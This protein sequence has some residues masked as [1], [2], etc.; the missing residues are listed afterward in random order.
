MFNSTG[1]HYCPICPPIMIGK[2]LDRRGN[3]PLEQEVHNYSG[4]GVDIARCPECKKRFQISYKVDQI[5][6]MKKE[7]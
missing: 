6:E 7:K 1:P 5:T 3:P 4:C 2:K